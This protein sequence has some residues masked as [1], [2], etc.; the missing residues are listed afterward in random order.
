[1]RK[2][3]IISMMFCLV[4]SCEQKKD[5][6]EILKKILFD[7]FEG[8]K[9]QDLEKLNSLTTSDFRLFENGKIWT[10]DSIATIKKKF[11]SFT[12]EWKL[13]NM[14]VN[15][16][17]SSGDIVYFNHGELS[18]NDTLK[19]KLDWLESATFR[20]IGGEWKMNFLHSTVRK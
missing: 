4:A 12:G 10:N 18:F 14:K 2:I 8:I 9:T 15:M 3:L 7:Y 6:P 13:E 11:N 5:N 17:E 19:M 16:D 1:M 20:K